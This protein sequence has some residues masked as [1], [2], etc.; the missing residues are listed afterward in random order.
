M[1]LPPQCPSRWPTSTDSLMRLSDWRAYD[2]LSAAQGQFPNTTAI[3]IRSGPLR[4][5]G[6]RFRVP[7]LPDPMASGATLFGVEGLPSPKIVSFYGSL[8][9]HAAG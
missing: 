9:G 1:S 2:M 6:S 8:D 3:C 5:A 4:L 7:Y